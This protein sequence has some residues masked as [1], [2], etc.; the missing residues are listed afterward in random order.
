MTYQEYLSNGEVGD[1]YVVPHVFAIR[2]GSESDFYTQIGFHTTLDQKV[3]IVQVIPVYD[4]VAE[5]RHQTGKFFCLENTDSQRTKSMSE[6]AASGSQTIFWY[7]REVS[8]YSSRSN[9]PDEVERGPIYTNEWDMFSVNS[10]TQVQFS[11]ESGPEIELTAVTEQQLDTETFKQE[12]KYKNLSMIGVGVFAGRGL[13]NLRNITALVNK[14]SFAVL[15]KTL[16]MGRR[17]RQSPAVLRQ[18]FLSTPCLTKDNGIG[19]YIEANNL[20]VRKPEGGKGF[21]HEQQLAG[22]IRS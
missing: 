12:K 22:L 9:Y 1:P 16:T 8:A 13:Q 17:L 3:E 21:L 6:V 4:I 2:R 5:K 10:D 18:T 19:K 7:G 14:A 15:L 20:D 11:F